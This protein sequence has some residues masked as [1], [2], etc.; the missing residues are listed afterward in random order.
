MGGDGVDKAVGLVGDG[1]ELGEH[2]GPETLR[3]VVRARGCRERAVGDHR[4]E[5]RDRA[6][7][8]GHGGAGAPQALACAQRSRCPRV[9]RAGGSPAHPLPTQDAAFR[10]DVCGA[11]RVPSTNECGT[12]G[13]TGGGGADSGA[14]VSG[15]M[16]LQMTS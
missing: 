10:D 5:Q 9:W 16:T 8:G 7:R 6:A 3:R 1:V 15:L 12:V 2:K 11:K 4:R 13:G 14:A